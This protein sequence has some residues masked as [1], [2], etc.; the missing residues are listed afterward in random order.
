MESPY[1][2]LFAK[3]PS[4]DHLRIFG[5]VCFVHLPPHERHKL[6]AQSVRCAFLGYNI[7]QKGFVC[8]DPTLHRTHISKNVIFFENQHF[9]LVSS[10][11]VSPSSTMVL[12]S[13]E[14]QFSDLHPVSSCFQ[15]GIVYTRHSRPQ[16]L[17]MAHPIYDPT[18]LQIQSV[19]AP[20]SPLVRC[21][22]R[23]SVL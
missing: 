19:A 22:F 1:F 2:H 13:F 23:V 21:S 7:C 12:P 3:Q 18:T 16:S 17:S 11:T 20:P 8:Y 5:C 6:S 4:Y 10:S 9:F 15:P 14:Q